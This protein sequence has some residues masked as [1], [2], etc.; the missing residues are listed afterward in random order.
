MRSVIWKLDPEDRPYAKA[1]FKAI[2]KA[3]RWGNLDK[4]DYS[5]VYDESPEKFLEGILTEHRDDSECLRLCLDG[6][7]SMS[8]FEEPEWSKRGEKEVLADGYWRDKRTG[9][10]K[11]R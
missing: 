4:W 10:L 8:V 5:H 11:V 9:E 2:T 3:R 1:A 7:L 6:F